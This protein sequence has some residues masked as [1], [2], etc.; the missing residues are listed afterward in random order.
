MNTA[1]NLLPWRAE[2]RQRR[3]RHSLLA[4]ALSILAGGMAWWWLDAAADARLHAQR[5]HNQALAQQL[6]ELDA[7]IEA[8]ERQQQQ[9]RDQAIAHARL[10]HERLAFI[11]LLDA[12][13]RRTP[14][15]VTLTGVQQQGDTLSFTAHA[16]A[17]AQIARTVQQWAAAGAGMPILSTI[18]SDGQGGAG[19]T[20][21][22]SL[23][24]PS[25]DDAAQMQ[26]AQTE[27]GR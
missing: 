6:A 17:S 25:V 11:R 4:L 27:A 8:F 21:S 19:Y 22:L 23:P 9:Q 24:W 14:A 5:Q 13:A 2:R 18:T 10:E 1:F 26:L 15:G 16:A 20:F 7:R 3:W 12:L